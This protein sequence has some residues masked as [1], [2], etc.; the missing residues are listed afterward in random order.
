MTSAPEENRPI[1]LA[2]FDIDG[3]LL[4]G[5]P[6]LRGWFQQSLEE[7]FG[8]SGGLDSYDFSGKTDP[9]IVTELMV[10]DGLDR[11]HVESRLHDFRDV[12]L[13]RLDQNL[14][15]EDMVLLPEVVEVLERLQRIGVELGLLTGNWEKGARIKLSRF[16]LN[17]FF[18][19]GAFGDGQFDRMGLP[20]VALASAE[21]SSGQSFS[22]QGKR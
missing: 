15:A 12:Y 13:G 17:R 18:A 2:L 7:V 22:A 19:F 20:P 4:R 8:S 1:R 3:T 11:Q 10:G 6:A 16:D 9:Q 5:T 14:D 21:A